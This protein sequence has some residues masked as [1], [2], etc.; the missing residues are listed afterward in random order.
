MDGTLLDSKK[1]ISEDNLRSL[2]ELKQKGVSIILAS[3]RLDL[4]IKTYIKQLELKG[5]IISCNGGLI[6]N[7]ETGEILYSSVIEH[8]M[9]RKI[10][11]YAQEK[12]INYLIYTP[13]FVYSNQNNP[14]SL[15]YENNNKRH[16]QDLRIPLIYVNEEIMKNLDTLKILKVLY[17]C[18]SQKEVE[19]IQSELSSFQE[20]E[21]VSSA[22][23]LLDIMRAGTTK[24]KALKYLA[25]R[26]KVSLEEVIA[27][28]DN[29]NDI[30]MLGCVG[31]PIAMENSVDPVKLAA[32]FITKSNEESGIAYAIDNF[33]QDEK[34]S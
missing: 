20:L 7:I 24:G 18:D 25:E 23:G 29:Y 30:E 32:R 22:E 28:G 31:M 34:L 16:A 8:D 33:L 15:E 26:Q 5:D 4:M 2:M 10:I 12:N 14:R 19:D 1:R 21:V 13:D 11:Q 17:I 3:G 6:R 27:F 9:A